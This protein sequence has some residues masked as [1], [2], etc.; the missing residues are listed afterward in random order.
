MK[1]FILII[2]SVM[3]ISIFPSC[4]STKIKYT[5]EYPFLPA[6]E[7][8]SLEKFTPAPTNEGM[9]QASYIIKNVKYE[10]ILSKY[11]KILK[12]DE[13]KITKDDKPG[14]LTIEKDN[15]KVFLMPQIVEDKNS[16]R[17]LIFA[18]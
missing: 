8:M 7:G 14:A 6:Y 13:W 15:H 12:K 10:D 5:K 17:I 18:K 9:G 4:T 3:F 2:I 11:E 16:V 1:K